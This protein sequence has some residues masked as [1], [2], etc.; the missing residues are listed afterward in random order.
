MPEAIDKKEVVLSEEEREKLLSINI[1]REFNDISRNLDRYHAIF[2]QI[3]EMGYPRLT[4]DVDT[5]AVTFDKNGRNLEFLFNPV[6][7]KESDTYTK[8]FVIC[9]EC[10]HVILNHG[11]R[12]KDLKSTKINNML[13]NFALDVVINH[14]LVDKFNFDRLSINGH[15]NYCWIDTVY[16]K[17]HGKVE[18]N[19]AFEYY[20]GLLKEKLH[21]DAASGKMMI[22]NSDGSLSEMQGDLVDAHDFL[23]SIDDDSLRKKLEE[24]INQNVNDIDKK[25]FMDK[26]S[27]TGEGNQ[28]IN[29][30]RKAGTST[31]G[32]LFQINT[33]E[34][35]SK[36]KKWE[37]VI[38]KWSLKYTSQDQ[39]VEQWAKINRRIDGMVHDLMLPSD[40][41]DDKTKYDRIEVW[42]FC[43][44]SGSC[45]EFKDRFFKAARSLS[46]EKFSLRLFSFDT[47]VYDVDIK[48]GKVYGGGG[49]SFDILEKKIQT[50]MKSKNLKY[51][52]AVFVLTD[53]YGSNI[54]PQYPKRWYWFLSINYRACIP[55]DCNIHLLSQFE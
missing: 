41:D 2:Y 29:N 44:T 22:K 53:G 3:W 40:I 23:E 51:P 37:T 26:M 10:L 13:A 6:F 19:R 7:W 45:L 31:G 30:G 18:K 25:D 15:E 34:K 49:T 16:G 39:D 11:V 1:E 42:F 4:F 32:M 12:I 43:D 38:K 54:R 24:Q 50:E 36:K 52:H 46:P 17:D 47:T 33:K 9:H 35:V 21:K 5:A 48:T 28:S 55:K 20:F 27:K 8:E 14:M